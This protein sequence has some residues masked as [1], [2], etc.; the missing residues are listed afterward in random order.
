MLKITQLYLQPFTWVYFKF[1]VCGRWDTDH[2]SLPW[3]PPISQR[4]LYITHLQLLIIS[5]KNRRW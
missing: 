2:G 3:L 5:R 4:K 1:S